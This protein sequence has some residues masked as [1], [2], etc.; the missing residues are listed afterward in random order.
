[1]FARPRL[2][3]GRYERMIYF[4]SLILL[5]LQHP[6]DERKIIMSKLKFKY[7]KNSYP[8]GDHAGVRVTEM[9]HIVEVISVDN[10]PDG[11]EG[12]RKIDKENY[13]IV[14]NSDVRLEVHE[15][16]DS[17][18]GDK[19]KFVVDENTGEVYT[20]H[21]YSLNEN[22]SQNTAG[23]KRTM[24]KIRD[25]ICANFTGA[26]NE[27]F[28]M[29][30]YRPKEDGTPMN[31]VETASEDFDLFIKRFRRRYP[32][33]QYIAILEP[34]ENT[35]WHWHLLAKFTKWD[36]NEQI[37]IDNN[38]IMEPLW[39]H[40]FT[41]TRPIKHVD[42][43]GAYFSAYLGNVE[44]NAENKDHYFDTLYKSGRD[45]N[46]LEKEVTDEQGKK[47]TKKFIK[48]GRL[49][50]Y[51][52]GTNIYR[53]SR[54]I[55]KPVT[56]KMAYIEA[57]KNIIGEKPVDYSR[58]V[59]IEDGENDG[60]DIKK[61]NAVTYEQYNF[62]R[63]EHKKIKYEPEEKRRFV[64]VAEIFTLEKYHGLL[65]ILKR[66]GIKAEFSE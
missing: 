54:G 3:L 47:V 65:W 17:K 28:I 56:H 60:E 42:N 35:A 21:K 7:L 61:Y 20:Q 15:F 37:R 50:L 22:R 1:V 26:N 12:H 49:H 29:L 6:T 24:K 39:R 62:K 64:T 2:A 9:G 59:V 5:I 51:P 10:M 53:Y 33:L 4:R 52:S 38:S 41:G 58:T 30:T 48:G 19:R 23:I 27:L 57:K 44:I 40:G 25:L 18:T 11:L 43:M 32:D 55:V 63:G 46:I 13:V 16:T 34:Q 8:I 31:D 36:S 66:Q 45:I 14:D